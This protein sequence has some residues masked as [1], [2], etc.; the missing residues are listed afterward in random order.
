M[1]HNEI[2]VTEYENLNKDVGHFSIEGIFDDICILQLKSVPLLQ[3]KSV[4]LRIT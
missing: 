4:P 2:R 3:L 1:E